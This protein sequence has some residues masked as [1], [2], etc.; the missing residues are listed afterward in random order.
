[1]EITEL[2]REMA[3]EHSTENAT[4]Y[5]NRINDTGFKK[6]HMELIREKQGSIRNDYT[7]PRTSDREGLRRD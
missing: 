2:P 6:T 4:N 1:L 5:P 7:H 3:K